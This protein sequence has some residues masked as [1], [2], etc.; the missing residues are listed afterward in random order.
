MLTIFFT[1]APSHYLLLLY[2]KFLTG[3]SSNWQPVQCTI[4]PEK[5]PERYLMVTSPKLSWPEARQY[6]QERGLD[7]VTID[8]EDEMIYLVKM[9]HL[10]DSGGFWTGWNDRKIEGRLIDIRDLW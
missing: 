3:D 4:D 1:F 2:L 7:L 10:H 6:C 9:G 8:T 5:S